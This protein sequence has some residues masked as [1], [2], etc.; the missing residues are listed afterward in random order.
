[1]LQETRESQLQVFTKRFQS[2][3]W[4]EVMTMGPMTGNLLG[5]VA[6]SVCLEYA[7]GGGSIFGG[8]GPWKACITC[9]TTLTST[10]GAMC[11]AFHKEPFQQGDVRPNWNPAT[12]VSS[13]LLSYSEAQE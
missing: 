7:G 9:C 6:C 12:L 10:T 5:E 8:H 11:C 3:P 4:T 1:M 13:L 2:T